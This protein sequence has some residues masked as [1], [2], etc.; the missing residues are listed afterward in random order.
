[1]FRANTW[2]FEPMISK[3]PFTTNLVISCSPQT[4]DL[5]GFESLFCPL[6]WLYIWM[7]FSFDKYKLFEFSSSQGRSLVAKDGLRYCK[8][9]KTYYLTR[10]VQCLLV[11]QNC[12]MLVVHEIIVLTCSEIWPWLSPGI[13]HGP[14]WMIFYSN[15]SCCTCWIKLFHK[16]NSLSASIIRKI[17]W[18]LTALK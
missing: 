12:F 15:L 18:C 1:M 5:V 2:C 6:L 16:Y 10:I 8:I 9:L 3:L 13:S 17:S 4:M 14:I 7:Q 11:G